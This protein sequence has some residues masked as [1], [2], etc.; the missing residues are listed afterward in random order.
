MLVLAFQDEEV[1]LVK[2]PQVAEVLVLAFQDEEVD[3]VKSPHYL[4]D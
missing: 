1:G 2:S 4:G 3:L